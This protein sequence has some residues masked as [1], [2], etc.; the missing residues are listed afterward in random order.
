MVG[1]ISE[2]QFR[3]AV[4]KRN[5]QQHKDQEI[6]DIYEVI[7]A[8]LTEKIN[9]LCQELET[10]HRQYIVTTDR[11]KLLLVSTQSKRKFNTFV[12]KF[13]MMENICLAKVCYI[14]KQKVMGI[15]YGGNSL[16]LSEF[17]ALSKKEFECY[18]TV[19]EQQ[20]ECL[21]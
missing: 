12:E 14:Y 16:A 2:A 7:V 18:K 11:E 3:K 4:S 6:L 15:F 17:D 13:L 1:E 19:T 5:K 21:L 8:V 20:I 9:N 10:Y